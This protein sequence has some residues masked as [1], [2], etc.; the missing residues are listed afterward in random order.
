MWEKDK[1]NGKRGEDF[2][3]VFEKMIGKDLPFPVGAFHLGG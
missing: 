1:D 3:N 2:A